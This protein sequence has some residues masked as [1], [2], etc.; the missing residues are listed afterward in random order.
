MV[1]RK[2]RIKLTKSSPS[3]SV[4]SANRKARFM[5]I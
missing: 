1:L 5:Y 3:D 4:Y 2:R